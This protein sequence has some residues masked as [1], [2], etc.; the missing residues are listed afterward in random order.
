MVCELP[1]RDVAGV[2]RGRGAGARALACA[3]ILLGAAGNVASAQIDARWVGPI[4]APPFDGVWEDADNWDSADFPNNVGMMTFNAILDLDPGMDYVVS[5]STPILLSALRLETERAMIDGAGGGVFTVESETRLQGGTLMGVGMLA[6][7]G[8]LIFTSGGA[9]TI[10]ICDTCIFHTGTIAEWSGG[11]SILLGEGAEIVNGSA[12]TF[13]IMNAGT[14]GYNG[15]GAMGSFMNEGELVKSGGGTTEFTDVSLTNTGTLRVEAGTFQTNGVD[16]NGAGNTLSGGVWSVMNGAALDLVG[17]VIL[18]NDADV[19]LSGVG[20]SFGAIDLLETNMGS[21]LIEGG[22]D[23]TTVPGI[24][25]TNSGMLAVGAGTAF[26]V[27]GSSTLGNLTGSTLSGGMFEIEGILKIDSAAAVTVVDAGVRLTGDSAAIVDQADASVF[28]G[29]LTI[30]GSGGFTVEGRSIGNPFMTQGDLTVSTGG[31][32]TIG[33]GTTLRVGAGF[34]FTNIA[35]GTLF[36]GNLDIRGRLQVDAAAIDRIATTLI[37]DTPDSGIVDENGMD[38]LGGLDTLENLADL[39]VRTGRDLDIIGSLGMESGSALRIGPNGKLDESIVTIANNLTQDAGSTVQMLGGQLIVNGTYTIGGELTGSGTV[40]ASEFIGTGTLGP[41]SSPGTL[42]LDGDYRQGTG[43]RI[44]IEIGGLT[45]GE[46]YD[47]LIIHGGLLF[48]GG[49][50]GELELVL[51]DGF[52]PQV[53]DEFEVI[54]FGWRDG[55]FA[56]AEAVT[57]GGVTLAPV[58]GETS[59]R[60]VTIPGPGGFGAALVGAGMMCMRRRRAD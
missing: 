34:E 28:S 45:P 30:G 51:I 20:S 57:I 15:M 24:T 7:Q 17:Q 26:T 11:V 44:V 25:F 1:D 58:W 31:E 4:A 19:R 6:S 23:F 53:G 56:L 49:M 39:T 55:D 5:V 38:A 60:L 27:E 21:F 50:A 33:E 37:L 16:V 22:R 46:S 29:A 48:D 36:D 47:Q 12:S 35:A 54:L 40:S 9:S 52:V 3:M 59:L 42:T 2:V 10:D 13:T 18:T 32:L 8:S 41:G 43:G 14:L